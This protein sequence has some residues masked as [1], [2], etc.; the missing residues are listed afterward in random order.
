MT[1]R[2]R[3]RIEAALVDLDFVPLRIC[4]LQR[5]RYIWRWNTNID[6]RIFL[7]A[8]DPPFERQHEIAELLFG[9]PVEAVPAGG[10]EHGAVVD[11][12]GRTARLLHHL[13]I[14]K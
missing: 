9:V 2:S 6:S 5:I 14:R 7:A 11:H 13:P 10:L 8:A 1:F 4:G 3:D 12:G